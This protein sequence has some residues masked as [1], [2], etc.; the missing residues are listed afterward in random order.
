[1]AASWALAVLAPAFS[2]LEPGMALD[3][4]RLAVLTT[5]MFFLLPRLAV[6]MEHP[7]LRTRL[8]DLRRRLVLGDT[9][10]GDAKTELR[11][12]LMG[13]RASRFIQRDVARFLDAIQATEVGLEKAERLQEDV[14]KKLHEADSTSRERARELLRELRTLAATQMDLMKELD[15]PTTSAMNALT[16]IGR[17]MSWVGLAGDG[18]LD[19]EVHQTLEAMHELAGELRE[20][21]GN[22][23]DASTRTLTRTEEWFSRV[24]GK[25]PT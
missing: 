8:I 14:D 5:A 20:R 21:S 19:A 10:E 16:Q 23:Y 3:P 4:F 9:L 2:F 11:I 1:V 7:V 6:A 17:K 25:D 22:L 13:Q 15:L 12:L 24:N 18:A